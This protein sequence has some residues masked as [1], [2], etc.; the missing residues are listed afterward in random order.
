M[1]GS[2]NSNLK[3]IFSDN[4]HEQQVQVT[5]MGVLFFVFFFLVMEKQ[6]VSLCVLRMHKERVLERVWSSLEGSEKDSIFILKGM[7]FF[8]MIIL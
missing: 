1:E 2:E 7:V 3:E 5:E 4:N 8:L 6:V